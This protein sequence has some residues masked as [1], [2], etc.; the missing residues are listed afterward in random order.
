MFLNFIVCTSF[1]QRV[2]S[3]LL[4]PKPEFSRGSGSRGDT[5]QGLGFET[6]LA[7]GQGVAIDHHRCWIVPK[8]SQQ[9]LN[10]R[11]ANVQQLTRKLGPCRFE[12]ERLVLKGK[13]WGGGYCTCVKQ[14]PFV[15]LLF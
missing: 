6:H 3:S 2:L 4:P 9:S 15:K 13:S 1:G 11:G 8:Q 14:V 12:V 10:R 5:L 7:S